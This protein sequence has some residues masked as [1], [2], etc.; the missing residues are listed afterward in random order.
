M[1]DVQQTEQ[2]TPVSSET[3]NTSPVKNKATGGGSFSDSSTKKKKSQ[4]SKATHPPTSEMVNNA[5][6]TLQERNGSSLQAIKK[7]MVSNYKVDAEKMAPFIKKFLKTAIAAGAIVQTK[8]KGASGSFKLASASA[9]KSGR[10]KT[11]SLKKKPAAATAVSKRAK[12]RAASTKKSSSP[13][14]AKTTPVSGSPVVESKKKAAVKAKK[15][16]TVGEKKVT[17]S[18]TA[19]VKKTTTVRKA[20]SKAKKVTKGPTKK[21]KAPKPKTAKKVAGGAAQLKSS[22]TKKRSLPKKK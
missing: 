10:A 20:P 12:A 22:S 2:Q 5:I 1:T 8:G 7:Y 3:E 11:S 16:P 21:P 4:R 18:T 9:K 15:S 14:K 19:A 6:K 17:S 13:A